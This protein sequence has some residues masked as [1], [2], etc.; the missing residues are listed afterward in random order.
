[1]DEVKELI[2]DYLAIPRRIAS[3][4]RYITSISPTFYAHHSIVGGM[5]VDRDNRGYER[6]YTPEQATL[7]ITIQEERVNVK[8]KRLLER[9]KLF[10]GCLARDELE[11]LKRAVC[12]EYVTPLERRVY[13]DLCEIEQYMAFKYH[14]VAFE[15]DGGALG[16]INVLKG[17]FEELLRGYV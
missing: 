5:Q 4:E 14:G 12:D 1:M 16:E 11:V 13:S 8:I 17:E 6:S 10:V 7:I 15:D 3:L 9:W 2:Q